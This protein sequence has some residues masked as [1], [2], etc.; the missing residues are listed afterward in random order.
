MRAWE[1]VSRGSRDVIGVIQ[2]DLE[3]QIPGYTEIIRSDNP[4]ITKRLRRYLQQYTHRLD[5]DNPITDVC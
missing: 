2:S 5:L 1:V 3:G 4:L